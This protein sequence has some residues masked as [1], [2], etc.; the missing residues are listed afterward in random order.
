M[1]KVSLPNLCV[2]EQKYIVDIIFKEFLGISYEVKIHNHDKIHITDENNLKNI[3]L[4]ASFFIKAN[5]FWLQS[6][7]MPDNPLA[8]WYPSKEGHNFNLVNNE[9]PIIYGKPGVIKSVD[10]VHI[11]IDIFGS[12]FFMLSRYEELITQ[13]FDNHGRFPATASVAYKE[14]FLD[15]FRQMFQFLDH[16]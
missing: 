3:T 11:N 8:R 2:K 6:A 14:S 13:S 4:D 5:N 12:A 1:L 10:S 15:L 9:I 16:Y 7:S